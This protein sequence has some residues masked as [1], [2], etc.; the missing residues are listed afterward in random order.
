MILTVQTLVE[1]A[2]SRW[3]IKFDN[4]QTSHEVVTRQTIIHHPFFFNLKSVQEQEMTLHP[5][6]LLEI[7][8]NV[9]GNLVN[10]S[11]LSFP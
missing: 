10:H 6:L 3:L 8:C 7:I 4:R 5:H 2:I 11:A 1:L 9:L